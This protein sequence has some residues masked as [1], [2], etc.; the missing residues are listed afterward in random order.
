MCCCCLRFIKAG[1]TCFYGICKLYC[2][3]AHAVCGNGDLIEGSIAYFLPNDDVADWTEIRSMWRRSY[4]RQ[5]LLAEWEK[6]E[7]SEGYCD[8]L[9]KSPPYDSE[10]AIVNVVDLH[11]FDFLQGE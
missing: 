1:N 2:D 3:A 5:V 9:R 8:E 6:E 11:I 7:T 4:N 10:K